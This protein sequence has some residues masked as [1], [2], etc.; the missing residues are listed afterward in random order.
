MDAQLGVV[1]AGGIATAAG[2]DRA[3]DDRGGPHP[4]SRV[5]PAMMEGEEAG[6]KQRRRRVKGVLKKV[7]EQVDLTVTVMLIIYRHFSWNFT[8]VM[9]TFR[10]TNSSRRKWPSMPKAVSACTTTHNMHLGRY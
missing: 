7:Q 9:L 5:D 3:Q 1:P 10:E 2:L 6:L 8:L 4:S